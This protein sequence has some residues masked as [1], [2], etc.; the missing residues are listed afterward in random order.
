VTLRFVLIALGWAVIVSTARAD[1]KV[2]TR[3]DPERVPRQ[4]YV[5]FKE[6]QELYKLRLLYADPRSGIKKP[7]V[8]PDVLP[9]TVQDS[10]SLALALA[11]S[12]HGRVF[13]S[14]ESPY[15]IRRG[16][17]VGL[18]EDM[19]SILAKDPRVE[20]IEPNAVVHL[21]AARV[22]EPTPNIIGGGREAR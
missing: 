2:L 17:W 19:V 14:D 11:E 1:A 5:L 15:E 13:G 10:H 6:A 8:L 3:P 22:R 12:V 4:Y 9:I 18:P 16:F 21:S 7:T 20:S